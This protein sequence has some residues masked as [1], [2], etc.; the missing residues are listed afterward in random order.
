M[1]FY[2]G[3]PQHQN[4][5]PDT[6]V[7][8]DEKIPKRRVAI[9]MA[10]CGKGYYGL[11]YNKKEEE[12]LPT[13]E[14]EFFKALLKTGAVPADIMDEPK[15]M[16]YNSASRTDKHVSALGQVV[17][18]K[19][20]SRDDFQEVL[21]SYL[22]DHVRVLKVVRSTK[23]FIAK[24][25][26]EFRTY[27]YTMPS[28]VLMNH[29]DVIGPIKTKCKLA[30]KNDPTQ[31]FKM[32]KELTE[33][34]TVLPLE[35]EKLKTFRA[36]ESDIKRLDTILKRYHGTHS[37][38]NFTSGV[39]KGEMQAT[40]VMK[41][42]CVNRSYLPVIAD[43]EWIEV[44][45]IGQSFMI[46]QIRKMIGLALAMLTGWAGD[47]HFNRCF[48]ERLEDIPKAPGSG[49]LLE[50]VHYDSYNNWLVNNPA[51]KDSSAEPI[52]WTNPEIMTKMQEFKE[53]Y[54]TPIIVESMLN[55]EEGPKSTGLFSWLEALKRHDYTGC[56]AKQQAHAN[57]MG[58]KLRKL[59]PDSDDES[60]EPIPAKK[61]KHH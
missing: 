22:P 12:R 16:S 56:R 9:Q 3:Q 54:V 8:E 33:N 19:V 57:A 7:I 5:N 48:S 46:H 43:Y 36:T 40:R 42:V 38:H 14:G 30:A 2:L 13:V 27:S 10:Y 49:L 17:S 51:N 55:K 39:K 25:K 35:D 1:A 50:S 29:I 26:C 4:L 44:K 52:D 58:E 60:A 21:N 28:F 18:M 45:I 11:A 24:N 61:S 32:Q 53:K 47:D 6:Q 23:N 37:F 59:S 20:K 41:K 15:K 31:Y 34:I